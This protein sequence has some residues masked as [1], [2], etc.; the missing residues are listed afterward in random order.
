MYVTALNEV[1]KLL[2]GEGFP[3]CQSPSLRLNKFVRLSGKTKGEEFS[4]V[5][6]CH[7]K[8]SVP[9]PVVFSKDALRSKNAVSFS[10]T[11]AGN[12]IVNQAGGILENAGLC[13]HSHFGTPYIPGSAVKGVARHAAWVEW[14]EEKDETKK[15]EIAEKIAHVFG[16]PTGDKELDKYLVA[17]GWKD[18]ASS[19]SICFMSAIPNTVVK[20]VVDI[21]NCHHPDY[22]AGKVDTAY[23]NESPNPQVFPAVV[24]GVK[25]RFTLF[26]IKGRGEKYLEMA[27]GWLIEAITTSGVGA[28]TAAGYG[29]F[30]YDPEEAKREEARR[31]KQEAEARQKAEDLAREEDE[32]RK[33]QEKAAKRASMTDEDYRDEVLARWNGK[34][35]K[36][37]Y[38]SGDVTQF[39]KQPDHTKKG[40]VLALQMFEGI[41]ADVWKELKS[42][43][44]G[45][46][47]KGEQAIRKYCKD[48]NMGK[49]P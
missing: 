25:F 30:S 45:D 17:Q 8:H 44:K 33:A 27:K 39:D 41:G 6:Q 38:K 11:L 49:M 31:I 34:K 24:K 1:K 48:N 40:I 12:L 43:Q 4:A 37:I 23:D 2:G 42:G 3:L 32:K 46:V 7:F 20:L 15:K 14:N 10:A 16:Y 13:L 47:A 9:I 5:V 28:K 35:P 19:G 22:Y 21:V 36:Q 26:P 29:W 18:K